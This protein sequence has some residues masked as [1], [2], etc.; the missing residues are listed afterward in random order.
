MILRPFF[1]LL[2]GRLIFVIICSMLVVMAAFSATSA[3]SFTDIGVFWGHFCGCPPEPSDVRFLLLSCTVIDFY[4]GVA[5]GFWTSLGLN[6]AGAG[7][8]SGAAGSRPM[9]DTRF[10]LTR[11]IRRGS[12]LLHQLAISA[13]ALA[14][15]PALCYA[16]LLGWLNL[17]H[18]PALAH[19]SAVLALIP[20]VAAL[21][22]QP[23]FIRLFAA[24][25]LARFYLAAFSVGLCSYSVVTAMRWIGLSSNLW[26]RRIFIL[27]LVLFIFSPMLIMM[28]GFATQPSLLLWVLLWPARN[29]SLNFEPSSLGIALHFAFAGTLLCGCWRVLQRAEL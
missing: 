16:L 6:F 3:E 27:P 20:S 5:L 26:L 1:M 15:I 10:L 18:A 24:A 23:S 21:G 7:M 9:G 12:I 17:V 22:P 4:M 14:L 2:R 28:A 29:A 13:I 8:A 19:L 25:H 11:P